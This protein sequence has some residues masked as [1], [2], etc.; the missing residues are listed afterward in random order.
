MPE[1]TP[2]GLHTPITNIVPAEATVAQ[3]LIAE[4]EGL[5]KPFVVLKGV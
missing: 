2:T 1:T 5:Q 3:E 4:A